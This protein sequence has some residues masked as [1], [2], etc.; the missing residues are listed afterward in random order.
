MSSKQKRT[1]GLVK[2]G[3]TWHIDKWIRGRRLCESAG[4]SDSEEAEKYLARRIEEIRQAEV[5][6]VRPQRSFRQAATKHLNES[7]KATVADDAKW[8]RQVDQFIGDLPLNSVHMGVLAPFIESRRKSGV[9]SR[10][11]NQVLKVVG[12]VLNLAANEWVDEYGLSWLPIAPKIRL[13]PEH[14]A[15]KPYPIS[16]DEQD[17]LF[18][19]LPRHLAQMC[20]FKVNTGCREAEVCGMRWSWEVPVTALEV[21]VFIIPAHAVKNRSERLVVL[22][23]VARSVIE[24]VRGEDPEYVFTYRGRRI[25]R[26]NNSGWRRARKAADL[27]AVRVHDLKHTFGRRLRAAGVSFEDRQDLLG[28]KSGRITT[29]YSAAEL[30]NLLKGAESICGTESRKSPALILLRGQISA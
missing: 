22:N 9:K 29:H 11:I 26:I 7:I 17:R 20:L 28:H 12:H 25:K 21:S 14:D 18:R 30:S 5:Y 16:W 15:R 27:S 10:T 2:R 3:E 13:L 8:L 6:G 19:Y 4:T 23:S 24:A 1:P